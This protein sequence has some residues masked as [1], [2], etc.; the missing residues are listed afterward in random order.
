MLMN[1][2]KKYLKKVSDYAKYCIDAACAKKAQAVQQTQLRQKHIFCSSAQ[3]E[4]QNALFSILSQT[5][6]SS[7]L[8]PL[9]Y[10]SDLLPN[11]FSIRLGDSSVYY[12]LWTKQNSQHAFPSVVLQQFTQKM[13][14]IISSELQRTYMTFQTWDIYSQMDFIQQNPAMYNGFRVIG[15]KDTGND[16]LLAVEYL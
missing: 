6:I 9:R 16:I 3:Y 2:F 1:T 8:S 7:Q 15:C 14:A 11:G 12:F 5:T 10:N 13:N 4:L